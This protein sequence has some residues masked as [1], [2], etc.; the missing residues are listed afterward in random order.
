MYQ[1]FPIS[2]RSR[3]V[4]YI[5]KRK[6][7]KSKEELENDNFAFGYERLVQQD[8][9]EAAYPLHDVLK[10]IFIKKFKFF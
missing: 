6:P 7:Y 5:L 3:I 2:M 4:Q 9:Y 8:V 1:I 10:K